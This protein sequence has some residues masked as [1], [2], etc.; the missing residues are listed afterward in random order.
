MTNTGLLVIIRST[1]TRRHGKPHVLEVLPV[2]DPSVCPV[3][4]WKNYYNTVRP[5]PL[6]PAFMLDDYTPQTPGPVVT[7]MR[8]A[9]SN[10]GQ[11]RPTNVSFHSLRRGGAQTAAKNGATQEQIMYHGT[12]KSVS[13]VQA[14]L[15]QDLRMVPAILAKTLAK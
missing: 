1:K 6:G 9:L 7:I 15:K 13:G 14:Y 12:W 11:T 2:Q 8:S 4:A 10:T 3:L 5:C